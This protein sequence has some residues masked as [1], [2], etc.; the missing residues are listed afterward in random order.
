MADE[1]ESEPKGKKGDKK[2]G[3]AK[4]NTVPAVVVALGLILMGKQMGGAKA[5]P[6]AAP[7]VAAAANAPKDCKVEDIK[8][9]PKE[10]PVAKLDSVTINLANGAYAKVG[11]ALQLSAALTLEAFTAEGTSS[12]ATDVLISVIGGR[13]RAEFASPQAMDALKEKIT[14]LVRPK[15]DCVV[16]DVLFTEFVIQS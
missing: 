10:G 9:P 16:L 6:A 4:S 12:K 15:F 5:A 14:D 7:T 13:D 1:E 8:S 11:I 2:A 3:K